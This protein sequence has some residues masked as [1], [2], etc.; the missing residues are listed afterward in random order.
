MCVEFVLWRGG[1]AFLSDLR[2]CVCGV[3]VMSMV[4]SQEVEMI[5]YA[6]MM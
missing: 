3:G 1:V 4:L 6:I 2:S 5:Y